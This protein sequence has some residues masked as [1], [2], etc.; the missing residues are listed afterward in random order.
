MWGE[1]SSPGGSGSF[2][3]RFPGGWWDSSLDSLPS[4]SVSRDSMVSSRNMRQA[5]SSADRCSKLWRSKQTCWRINDRKTWNK[6]LKSCFHVRFYLFFWKLRKEWVL[7]RPEFPLRKLSQLPALSE[8]FI[9]S[10]PGSPGQVS[11]LGIL[12]SCLSGCCILGWR[13]R[14]GDWFQFKQIF[15]TDRNDSKKKTET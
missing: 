5:F 8:A 11:L 15:L 14:W 7:T 4:S 2:W 13:G 6:V 12:A 3:T 10:G 1:V 9:V